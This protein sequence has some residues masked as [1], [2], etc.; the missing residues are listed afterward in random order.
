MDIYETKKGDDSATDTLKKKTLF[1]K[2]TF[3]SVIGL[4]LILFQQMCGVNSLIFNVDDVFDSF[5]IE[6]TKIQLI[7]IGL[8]VCQVSTRITF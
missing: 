5:N 4:G 7:M 3:R 6:N 1:M 8:F 2:A